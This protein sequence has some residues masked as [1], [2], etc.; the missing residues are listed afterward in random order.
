VAKRLCILPEPL[1]GSFP[2]LNDV[3]DALE[4]PARA[5]IHGQREHEMV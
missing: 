5:W 2:Q 4:Q 1:H 3:A